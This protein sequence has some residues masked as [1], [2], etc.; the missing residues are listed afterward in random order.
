MSK[1]LLGVLLG[2]VLG[3]LDGLSS[4]FYPEAVPMIKEI[5]IGSTVKGILTGV[6]IG[7]FSKKVQSLALGVVFGLAVGLVLSFLVAL[8]PDPQGQHHYF[9][10]M[11]PGGI[12]GLVVGFATQK[13]GGG[14]Q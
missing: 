7:Y 9:E 8:I 2:G 11:L 12:L 4:L 5:V 10:I 6:A 1:L 3:L 13:F 14:S